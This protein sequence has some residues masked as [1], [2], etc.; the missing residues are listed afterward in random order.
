MLFDVITGISTVTVDNATYKGDAASTWGL[1]YSTNAGSTWTESGAAVTTTTT[2][3]TQTFT[4]NI[5]G[6]ARLQIRKLT[7][8]TNR[9]NIDN[10]IIN[11]STGGGGTVVIAR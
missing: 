10:I 4:I 1:W 11:N 2:L 5:T 6:N 3:K 7:G 8:G 9:I